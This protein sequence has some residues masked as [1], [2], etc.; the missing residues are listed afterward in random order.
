M[1]VWRPLPAGTPAD[2]TY[3]IYARL[4]NST[5]NTVA[6]DKTTSSELLCIDSNLLPTL[7]IV[8][9]ID[10]DGMLY[11]QN[12]L[13]RSADLE[14][15]YPDSTGSV[16]YV[17]TF[18]A[19]TMEIV[20]ISQHGL[21]RHRRDQHSVRLAL[22]QHRGHFP[23]LRL[24]ARRSDRPDRERSAPGRQHRVPPANTLSLDSRSAPA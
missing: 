6:T 3:Y 17:G 24:G 22:R 13:Q 23:G 10:G 18:D 20:S 9:I 7:G 15:Q 8:D 12:G 1:D 19:S 14:V 11:M 21:R 16:S 2:G 5:G 4:K